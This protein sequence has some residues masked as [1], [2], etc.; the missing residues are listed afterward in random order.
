MGLA[1]ASHAEGAESTLSVEKKSWL[2]WQAA[3]V[4][5][6]CRRDLRKLEFTERAA[7]P[8]RKVMLKMMN[9]DHLIRQT[10]SLVLHEAR[11]S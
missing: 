7:V 11:I 8:K 1:I 3:S 5:F 9:L 2:P 10:G 4:P 6:P